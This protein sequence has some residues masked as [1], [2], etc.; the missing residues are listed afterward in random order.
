[1]GQ[2]SQSNFPY[3][4]LEVDHTDELAQLFAILWYCEGLN[5]LDFHLYGHNTVTSDVITQVF[6]LLGTEA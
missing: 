1:M 2:E 4:T 5:G 6:K 3:V